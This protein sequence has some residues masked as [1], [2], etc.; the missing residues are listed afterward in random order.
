MPY[1]RVGGAQAIAVRGVGGPGLKRA[2]G[3]AGAVKRGRHSGPIE[4]RGE[5]LAAI[6]EAGQL[7]TAL[8]GKHAGIDARFTRDGYR[9][10]ADDLLERMINPFL[11]DS[12]ERVVRAAPR[13]RPRLLAEIRAVV[14]AM[15]FNE[16]HMRLLQAFRGVLQPFHSETSIA[17]GKIQAG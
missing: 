2:K 5:L 3:Q 6:G 17:P 7:A 4:D 16:R 15:Q 13:Q 11:R 9:A 14:I 12:I 1:R 10:D 8:I